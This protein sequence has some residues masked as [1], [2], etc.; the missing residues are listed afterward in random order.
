MV[1]GCEDEI[2]GE[3][4]D[5]REVQ[6]VEVDIRRECEREETDSDTVEER[7][8]QTRGLNPAGWDRYQ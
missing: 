6:R 3:D 7:D 5:E 1:T 8:G 4:W 2:N